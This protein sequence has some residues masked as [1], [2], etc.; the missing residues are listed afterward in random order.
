MQDIDKMV[1]RLKENIARVMVG[2]ES[3]VELLLCA[4]LCRGHV[5]I[6]DVPGV[7]KTTLVSAL[8]RSLG[9]LVQAHPVYA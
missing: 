6:E 8:A 7:G 9:L 4:L 2:K 3:A 5:L 1:A